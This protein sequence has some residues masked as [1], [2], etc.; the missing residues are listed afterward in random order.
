MAK[1]DSLFIGTKGGT[2]NRPGIAQEETVF[3]GKVIFTKES[4]A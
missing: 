1:G 2:F 3:R 4:A